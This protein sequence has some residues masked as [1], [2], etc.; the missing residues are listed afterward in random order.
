M[1]SAALVL[2]VVDYAGRRVILTRTQWEFHVLVPKP[3]MADRLDAVRTTIM[4]PSFVNQDANFPDRLC[5]YGP[6]SSRRR[7]L[8]MKVVIG[9]DSQNEGF[10]VTA[11]PL[12]RPGSGERRVWTINPS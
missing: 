2:D 12:D 5:L 9:Y 3:Y 10:V 7:P 11:Y 6:L 8:M 4:S 1:T